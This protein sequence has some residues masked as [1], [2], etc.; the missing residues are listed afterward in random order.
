MACKYGVERQNCLGANTQL[1]QIGY[2]TKLSC[3]DCKIDE[4]STI[5]AN[6]IAGD[7][8]KLSAKAK[9]WF[10]LMG[11]DEVLAKSRPALNTGFRCPVIKET[12]STTCS[13]DHCAWNITYP[14]SANCLL[15]YMHQQGVDELSSEEI[16]YLYQLPVDQVK[17]LIEIS[18]AALRSQAIDSHAEETSVTREFVY[19]ITDRVCCVC[20]SSADE[21]VPRSLRIESVGAVYCSK[22][23]KEE[24]HPRLVELEIEKGLRIERILDWSFRHYKSLSVAENALHIPRWLAYESSRKYLNKPIEEFF[25][26]IKASNQHRSVTL[27]RRT[28]HA[29]SWVNAMI[30]KVRPVSRQVQLQYG[31]PQ[32][33]PVEIKRRLQDLIQNL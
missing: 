29:P 19:F 27:I 32:V 2:A 33:N 20:E 18:I 21:F 12:I 23:C 9:R 22:E 14:W 3:G 6:V 17:N 5:A 31:P 28:W 30:E 8:K 15:A 13:L 7:D 10:R 25:P 24:K 26:S 4:A 11:F 16:S 1:V